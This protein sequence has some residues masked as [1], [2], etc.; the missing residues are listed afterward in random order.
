[1]SNEI[2]TQL[3]IYSAHIITNDIHFISANKADSRQIN[4]SSQQ[5]YR[6]YNLKMLYMCKGGKRRRKK[7]WEM[8]RKRT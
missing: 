5:V 4:R 3:Y 1:M 8:K 2:C 7:Q 6:N